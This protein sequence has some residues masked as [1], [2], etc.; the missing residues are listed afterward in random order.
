MEQGALRKRCR[1]TGKGGVGWSIAGAARRAINALKPYKIHDTTH[2]NK[3][4]GV[5]KRNRVGVLGPQ[6]LDEGSDTD[7]LGVRNVLCFA[8]GMRSACR[9]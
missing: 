6:K 7:V 2:A 9:T 8:A 1:R 3:S 4:W 5:L